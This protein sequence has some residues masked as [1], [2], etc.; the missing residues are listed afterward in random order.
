[1][2]ITVVKASKPTPPEEMGTGSLPGDL[3]PVWS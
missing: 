2:V 3:G 1:M